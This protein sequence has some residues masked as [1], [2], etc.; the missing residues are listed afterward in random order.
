MTTLSWPLLSA[1]YAQLR[2]QYPPFEAMQRA[3]RQAEGLGPA[4]A[5]AYDSATR[6]LMGELGGWTSLAVTEEGGNHPRAI[7]TRLD[8]GRLIGTKRFVTNAS[9]ADRIL[10]AARTGLRSDGR[11]NLVLAVV[12]VNAD[13]VRLVP[14][15]PLPF[16][17]EIDH[18]VVHFSGAAVVQVLPGDGWTDWVRPF[19]TVEDTFVMGAVAV[20]LLATARRK[21]WDATI[22]ARATALVAGLESLT[23]Q[24]HSEPSTHLAL[25]GYIHQLRALVADLPS[26]PCSTWT[27]DL[28]LM[29]IADKARTARLAKAWAA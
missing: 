2:L 26:V 8:E 23:H 21:G 10:V 4:F 17:P 20:F 29:T 12:D 28:P 25:A 14:M 22:G 11:P 9:Q 1:E 19:R 18:A 16:I 6:Q 27:R 13:G 5:C 7:H 3:A 15:P 24:P